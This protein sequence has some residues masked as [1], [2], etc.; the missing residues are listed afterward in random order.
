MPRL[1]PAV[2][3][4]WGSVALLTALVLVGVEPDGLWIYLPF[5]LSVVLLGL[6]HGA[7]D[8]V[9]L[10]RLRDAPFQA[11]PLLRVLTPYL[12]IGLAYLAVW[13]AMPVVA[14]VSF[15][16][17]TWAHWGQ[18]DV[19]SLL[20][21]TGGGHLVHRWQ[22]VWALVVR[23]AL[24]MFVPLLAFPEVYLAVADAVAGVIAE[25]T[26]LPAMLPR[27]V[28]L[29]GALAYGL[30]VLGYLAAGFRAAGRTHRQAWVLDAAEVA[31]LTAFFVTVHPLLAVGVYFCLWHALRHV[32]RLA[33]VTTAAP[34]APRHGWLASATT[35]AVHAIPT[36]AL[37]LVF[38]AG[39]YWIVPERP[40][41]VD[42]FIGLYLVLIAALTLPHVWV[43]IRMD[44]AEQVWT[45]SDGSTTS[46]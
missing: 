20:T 41:T 36:T 27:P 30:I 12:A 46:H 16:A 38:L 32:V 18:G 45:P 4:G 9:V 25:D 1:H 7:V 8:H 11:G 17:L 42:E 24:P 2:L 22:R 29:A 23:G 31:L 21:L 14:F 5:L 43:V 3:V 37:A 6:P 19:H 44:A 28:L 15:I 35:F 39:L 10:L 13:F 40:T 34:Q 33:A 26:G